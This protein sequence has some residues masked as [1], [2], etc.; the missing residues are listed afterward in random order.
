M[1]DWAYRLPTQLFQL[2]PNA[3]AHLQVRL[4]KS[5]V[6][7]Q[8]IAAFTGLGIFQGRQQIVRAVQDSVG[9]LPRLGRRLHLTERQK[10]YP[11]HHG[12][13]ED[14]GPKPHDNFMSNFQ[15]KW[16]FR[17]MTLFTRQRLKLRRRPVPTLVG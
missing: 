13:E 12:N 17:I 15:R 4:Q 1:S 6:P 2:A 10:R 11:H 7:G 16:T 8:Q 3:I 9:L 5:L 14:S